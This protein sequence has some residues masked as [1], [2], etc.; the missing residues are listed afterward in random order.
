MNAGMM[1]R[2]GPNPQAMFDKIEQ[3]VRSSLTEQDALR[4]NQGKLQKAK[5]IMAEL[6]GTTATPVDNLS[7]K[8]HSSIRSINSMAKLGFV[9]FGSMPDLAFKA[10][11]LRSHGFSLADRYTLPLA[12]LFAGPMTEEKRILAASIGTWAQSSFGHMIA[13]H[14][15]LD[16]PVGFLSKNMQRFF[17]LTGMEWLDKTNRTGLGHTLSKELSMLKGKEFKNLPGNTG[18][19]L[20]Q[21]MIGEKEWNIARKNPSNPFGNE[22]FITPDAARLYSKEDVA[23]YLGKDVNKLSD[24]EFS[25]VKEDLEDR[26]RTYFIDQADMV[27][28]QPGAAERNGNSY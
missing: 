5:F 3:S 27:N 18:N 19:L 4:E 9:A 26:W 14:S 17:K 8:I 22:Q 12:D 7:A 20:D 6:D 25:R 21:Y 2:L 11:V 10:S 13:F 15:A 1:K 16:S 24:E 28:I 23:E